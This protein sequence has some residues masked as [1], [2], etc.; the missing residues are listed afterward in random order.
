M[1]KVTVN[2]IFDK[3]NLPDIIVDNITD[4]AMNEC[5]YIDLE[6]NTWNRDT[7]IYL[8]YMFQEF[9]HE[10]VNPD[11]EGVIAQKSQ[12]HNPEMFDSRIVKDDQFFI[13]LFN[14]DCEIMVKYLFDEVRVHNHRRCFNLQ[15]L[16][17]YSCQNIDDYIW[18]LYDIAQALIDINN[19]LRPIKDIINTSINQIKNAWEPCE[20]EYTD[21][22]VYTTQSDIDQ[23]N[24]DQMYREEDM[25]YDQMFDQI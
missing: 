24:V 25:L 17:R 3:F 10:C 6:N 5:C 15:G 1:L 11:I 7:A 14:T 20:S 16:Y 18:V 2:K 8:S 12:V 23:R 13:K 21:Y 4:Y 9:L 22:S 19:P